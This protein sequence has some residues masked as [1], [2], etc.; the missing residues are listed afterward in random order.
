MRDCILHLADLHL[1]APV[2]GKLQ[3]LDAGSHGEF[4]R[5][6]DGFLARLADWIATPECRVGLVIIAGDLFHHHQPPDDV[7][8]RTRRALAR[9]AATV[10]VVTV[11][12]NHDEYS[13][14]R[15]VYRQGPWPGRLITSAEPDEAWQGE[16]EDGS[17]VVVTAVTY[18]AGK[19]RPG[20]TVRFPATD[21]NR[22][23]VA[24]AHGTVSDY[25]SGVVLEG[26]R[27][28][29]IDH[30]Q[31]ADA[32][33]RYLALGHI[34]ARNQWT[35]GNCTAVY[36]GPPVGPSPSDHGSGL[37]TLVQPGP[38]ALPLHTVNDPDLLGWRWDV[39]RVDVG[40]GERPQELA[41]RLDRTLPR[42][43]RRVLA[44]ELTGSVDRE[45]F[46][47]ELQQLLAQAGRAV[48]IEG[49]A[50]SLT[51]PP[52]LQ[53]LLEEQSLAG[54]FVRRWQQ[55]READ[56]PDEAHAVRVL[57]EGFAALCINTVGRGR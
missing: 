4:Q 15:C 42:E 18:E 40:P 34:H 14:A 30:Q 13:Y 26:E 12:G 29:T 52:D 31:V 21:P 53:V 23:G 43:A 25:F 51:P 57:R 50:V 47:G 1:G 35:I 2:T 38:S 37:L 10:P 11:P 46:A 49:R 17:R 48:L 5:S 16:L 8:A 44:V 6:R 19:A 22:F 24:V 39:R 28:F 36:P 20:A 9:V 56:Q 32:D 54:E 27:C 3:E 55:W 45:Q 41:E 33:Y 7:A